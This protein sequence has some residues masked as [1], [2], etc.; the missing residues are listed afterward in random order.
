MCTDNHERS[1]L[2]F[3]FINID[4]IFVWLHPDLSILKRFPGGVLVSAPCACLLLLSPFHS[5]P[6]Q[7]NVTSS[8]YM[9][10]EA[11]SLS[12]HPYLWASSDATTVWY[13]VSF[14]KWFQDGGT[15]CSTEFLRNVMNCQNLLK[16]S[17]KTLS[18]SYRRDLFQVHHW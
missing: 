14:H 10:L 5:I 17:M 4:S 1:S 7:I 9:E 11:P 18:N 3:Q 6:K 12:L 16:A 15:N 2:L 13:R 8:N